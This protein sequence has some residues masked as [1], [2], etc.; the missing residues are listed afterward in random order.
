MTHSKKYQYQKLLEEVEAKIYLEMTAEVILNKNKFSL[1][2][3]E[4]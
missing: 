2:Q 3:M 1:Q 4:L